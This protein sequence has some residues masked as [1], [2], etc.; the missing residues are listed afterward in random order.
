MGDVVAGKDDG[1]VRFSECPV[2]G[3]ERKNEEP[4]IG[5]STHANKIRLVAICWWV[6]DRG[7]RTSVRRGNRLNRF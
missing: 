1:T 7:L 2:M 4:K 6:D 3:W 5:C